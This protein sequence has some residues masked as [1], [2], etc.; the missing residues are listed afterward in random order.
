MKILI[1]D[2]SDT[3]RSLLTTI[4]RKEGYV[5][6]R[7]ASSGRQALEILMDSIKET[8]AGP[9]SDIDLI[10]MDF[11][12]PEMDG[13]EATRRIKEIPELTEIPVAMV[14]V[15]DNE[16]SLVRA[17]EVGAFDFI[18]KPVNKVELSVRV[19]SILR[20][21]AEMDRRKNRERE[22][23]KVNHALRTLSN[24]D[25]LT[26]VA[27]RRHFDVVAGREWYRARRESTPLSLIML[28]IDFFK[29]Y[30]DTYGHLEGDTCLKRVAQAIKAGARRPADFAARFGGEEF[31]VV[32]PNTDVEG[33]VNIATRIQKQIDTEAIAHASSTI[34]DTVTVSIGVAT[35][36][37]SPGL[38]LHHLITAAD[39]ALYE[40]KNSGRNRIV[41]KPVR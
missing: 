38:D 1:V 26:G 18:S 4:L 9:E 21:K 2:D 40:A 19:R 24:L 11:I 31:A 20:F 33:A 16:D 36:K 22:L 35:A 13:I 29:S 15:K 39:Q 41:I 3:S 30:N 6:L 23:E 14:T 8:E 34:A 7:E 37:P 25:G 10:L 5:A 27:N 28:D 12:M 32:L 17:F